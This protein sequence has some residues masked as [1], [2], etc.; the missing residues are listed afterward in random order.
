MV[1][2]DYHDPLLSFV[3]RVKRKALSVTHVVQ[4]HFP[5]KLLDFP[6]VRADEASWMRREMSS[7]NSNSPFNMIQL[8]ELPNHIPDIVGSQA[9]EP[10][11]CLN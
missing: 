6:T 7:W 8:P 3:F 10:P 2:R 11:E 5:M 4:L 1:Y 9:V